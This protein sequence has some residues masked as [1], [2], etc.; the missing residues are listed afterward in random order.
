MEADHAVDP[1][2]RATREVAQ[3][4]GFGTV[5][6]F[7]RRTRSPRGDRVLFDVDALALQTGAKNNVRITIVADPAPRCFRGP[8]SDAA[9]WPGNLLSGT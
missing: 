1:I 8:G 2:A 4:L 7:E 9:S 5:Q 3:R 6:L